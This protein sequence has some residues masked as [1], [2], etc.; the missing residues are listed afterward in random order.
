MVTTKK[1]YSSK[2]IWG[3]VIA[4]VGFIF[5]KLSV[6]NIGL[7]ENADFDQLS[8]FA[9]AITN[10]KGDLSSIIGTVLTGVGSILAIIGR[11]KADQVIGIRK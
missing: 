9:T 5:T 3:I 8:A 10:A 6:P 2:T 7:P 4:F 11:I 1:W